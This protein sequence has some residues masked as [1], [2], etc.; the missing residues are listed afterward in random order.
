LN[1]LIPLGKL[2][3]I[4]AP[5]GAGK[6]SLIKQLR[7]Q[8]PNLVVSVSHTTR[9]PRIGE[10]EAQDYFFVSIPTFEKMISEQAFLEYAL[11]FGN[12]YGTAIATIDQKLQQGID[13]ILEIDWQGARQIKQLKPDCLSIFILPPSI[14][15]LEQRLRQRG[16]DNEQIIQRRMSES[17]TELSHYFEYDYLIV[18]ADFS[19]ALAELKS[20][21]MAQRL[22]TKRQVSILSP[23]LKTLLN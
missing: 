8:L 23:W 4:S 1:N 16:Q 9:S 15:I 14:D 3:I 18:N 19:Q 17:L 7:P 10:S 13:V 21:F 22:L 5:S 20:I 2:Y 11:V 6:T 12:Y